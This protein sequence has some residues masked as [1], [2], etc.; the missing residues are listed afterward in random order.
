L[1]CKKLKIDALYAPAHV[2]PVYAPCP[3]IV[4]VL[5]LM[6]HKFPKY[7][8]W[9]EHTYFRFGV[10]LLTTR[11]SK[12]I[13]L[14]E[15]TRRD[16]QD[17]TSIAESKIEVIYPGVSEDFVL[18]NKDETQVIR[19]KFRILNPYILCVSSFHPRKNLMGL[20]DA[21]ELVS[22]EIHH[23]LVIKGTSNWK[24]DAV[25]SRIL[26][27]QNRARIRVIESNLSP[28]ELACLY[29]EADLFV[30]PSIYEG[31]GF[32]V[33]ESMA[34]GCPTI[35]TNVSSIPEIVGDAAILVTPGNSEE[36]SYSIYRVLSDDE[37]KSKLS[38]TGIIRA[39]KFS[40][41]I[42]AQNTIELF[43][44]VTKH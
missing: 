1:A 13:A 23:D 29:N 40:W 3:V 28:R 2:R 22:H 5:D 43:E 14:S 10:S 19:E 17:L 41:E 15:N 44:Q 16:L 37:L 34:C 38:K 18:I 21:F 39:R 27:S 26:N 35:T 36:L 12:V 7:W 8:R 33:L 6:Y 20:L 24:M 42:T 9:W 31:F 4:Q 32:P 30:F 25:G 11:A